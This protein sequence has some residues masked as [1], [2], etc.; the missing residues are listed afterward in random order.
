MWTHWAGVLQEEDCFAARDISSLGFSP[1]LGHG[2][3]DCPS[4][5][6]PVQFIVVAEN[7]IHDTKLRFCGCQPEGVD[8]LAQLM[9]A[10]MFPATVARPEVAFTFGLLRQLELLHLEC[11]ANM[12]D[13]TAYLQRL[14][15]NQ[16]P[17]SVAVS[18]RIFFVV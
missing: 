7:G 16:Y 8:R 9:R 6:P 2:G 14:T 3:Q 15:D 13:L 10:R 1:Q 12:Y 11:T 18:L 4:P 17:W 5:H